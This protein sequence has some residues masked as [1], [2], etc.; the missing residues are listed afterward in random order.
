M[1]LLPVLRDLGRLC[2][3]WRSD[4]DF[5]EDI[6]RDAPVMRTHLPASGRTILLSPRV[7]EE[8]L[9]NGDNVRYS[10]QS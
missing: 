5:T 3:R 2:H 1:L 8:I 10:G 7:E 6:P 9:I 4:E